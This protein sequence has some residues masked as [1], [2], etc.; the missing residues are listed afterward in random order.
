M[1]LTIF[2][3]G[4]SRGNPGPAAAGAVVTDDCGTVVREIGTFLGVTT[5]N[6]AEWT[7][8]IS[9]LQA[10]LELGADE[11]VIRLDSELVIKQ[12]TGVYRVKHPNMVPLHAQAK[13]LL[14]KFRHVDI[15]HVPRRENAAADAVVNAVLDAQQGRAA[16]L[17]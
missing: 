8:L 1:R 9:G 4:G 17:P 13:A 11:I 12:I 10:A 16:S 5:N 15:K 14:K 7:G 3:D 2:A 6:V